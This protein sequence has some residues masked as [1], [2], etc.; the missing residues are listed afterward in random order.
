MEIETRG[1]TSFIKDTEYGK[2]AAV[3]AKHTG[4][5]IAPTRETPPPPPQ[6]PD[7]A[8]GNNRWV[9]QQKELLK[10]LFNEE[11]VK[12]WA[13]TN[14][15]AIEKLERDNAPLYGDLKKAYDDALD[16]VRARA[17]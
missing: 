4:A 15:K 12:T 10:T 17:A 14:K 13:R 3:L 6:D 8:A 9:S 5:P 7:V 11:S 2:L 1:R 16:R